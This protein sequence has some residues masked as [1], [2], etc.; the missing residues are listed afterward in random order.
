MLD[1]H[2]ACGLLLTHA[3]CNSTNTLRGHQHPGNASI[4][5]TTW[6]G[7]ITITKTMDSEQ[8][9]NLE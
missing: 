1:M 5:G 9:K 6:C 7:D 3:A 2:I 4:V 8:E